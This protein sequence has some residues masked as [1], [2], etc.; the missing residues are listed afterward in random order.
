VEHIILGYILFFKLVGNLGISIK[1][2]ARVMLSPSGSV[3][4]RTD[5][6]VPVFPNEEDRF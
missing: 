5:F 3:S 4:E 1:Q 2:L 6:I